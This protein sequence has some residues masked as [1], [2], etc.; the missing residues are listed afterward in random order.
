MI[1][2]AAA[3]LAF[4][5]L[6]SATNHAEAAGSTQ[7]GRVLARTPALAARHNERPRLGWPP[8]VHT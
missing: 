6:A 4:L 7:R 8:P 5:T 1:R 3:F 2:E